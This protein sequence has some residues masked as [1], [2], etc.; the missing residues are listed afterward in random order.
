MNRILSS[1]IIAL[2]LL[3]FT[4]ISN[5]S[6]ILLGGS[7]PAPLPVSGNDYNSNLLGLGYSSITTGAQLSVNQDGYVTFTYIGAESGFNNSFITHAG[8]IT[9]ANEAFDFNGYGSSIT[10]NVSAND[11]LNFKFTSDGGVNALT[12]V[13]NFNSANLQGM[14]IFTSISLPL[15]QVVLG[16]D[17]QFTNDDDD[18]DDMLI[19]VDFSP[20][21]VPAA[22]WLFGSGLIVLTGVT[23]RKK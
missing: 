18:H 13:D 1:T 10:I 2:G 23:R 3:A 6:L 11:I 14:G 20:I 8:I 4:P 15:Q 19:R 9:E 12:P 17:D 5:A 21:P 22:V 16:Y 7:A